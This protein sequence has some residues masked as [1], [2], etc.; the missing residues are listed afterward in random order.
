MNAFYGLLACL[1]VLAVACAPTVA[2]TAAPPASAPTAVPTAASQAA[3]G[4]LVPLN[5][6]HAKSAGY[7]PLYVAMAK[8]YFKEQGLAPELTVVTA[9][10]DAMVFLANNQLDVAFAGVSV[11]M[12]NAINQGLRIRIVGGMAYQPEK[13]ASGVMIRQDLLD[14]GAIKGPA[15]LKGRKV[16]IPGGIGATNN[17]TV[18]VVLRPANLTLK[19]MEVVNLDNAAIL[20]AF[21]N[22]SIDSAYLVEPFTSQAAAQKIAGMTEFGRTKKGTSLTTVVFGPRLLKQEPELGRKFMAAMKKGVE[23]YMSSRTDPATLA[24]LSTYTGIQ[25]EA[26]KGFTPFDFDP[27]L[28]PDTRTVLDMQTMFIR[29]GQ[30]KYKPPL[31]LEHVTDMS[32]IN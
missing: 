4:T 29:D 22:K 3:S 31:T 24:I 6:A 5:V 9:G 10:Q 15:D 20:A 25:L 14:S 8:G 28:T 18:D 17:Y 30:I 32:F 12:F 1:A 26:L 19:D 2:P 23:D 7:A 11:G 27:Q 21:A 13:A 16:A